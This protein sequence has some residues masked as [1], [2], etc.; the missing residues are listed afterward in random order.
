MSQPAFD[1]GEAEF[2][3]A[4]NPTYGVAELAEAINAQLRRGFTD[5]VWVRG[6]VNG[7]SDRG[8]HT[9]FSLI[10]QTDEGKAVLNVQLFAPA[11]RRLRPLLERNRLELRNGMKVRI[12]GHLDFWA[13]G[14]RLG[15]KMAGLD[16]RYTLGEIAQTRDDVMRRLAVSGLLDA[17]A[18]LPFPPLPL[19]VGVAASLDS[20]AWHDFHDEVLRSGHAFHVTVVDTRVQGDTAVPMVAGAV[21]TLSRLDL[22]VI[23]VIRGGGARNELAVFD[24]EPIAR[25]IATSPLPV[26]TG[27]GHEIDRSV[28]DEVAHLA[29]KTPTACAGELVKRVSTYIDSAEAQWNGILRRAHDI[30]DAAQFDVA[31]RAHRVARRTHAA[32][33]RSDERLAAR[34]AL[35]RSRVPSILADAEARLGEKKL[36]VVER[37]DVLLE[38]QAGRVERARLR[39]AALDPAVQ[40][41][42]GW[43]ITRLADGRLVRSADEATSGDELITVVADGSITSTVHDPT[44]SE[45][46]PTR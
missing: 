16:P 23:V 12:F 41:A 21:G 34:A 35:L 6:E 37:S 9:Y 46:G 40:L 42:R 45:T 13:Q 43:S 33:E 1:F 30:V 19:R 20:A 18:R 44:E 3:D 17:N 14:G 29:L 28:A 4:T 39:L 7:L 8:P 32:V 31:D 22:D 15:L 5:G 11:K 25:A 2:D 10:E 26:L 27:L 24:A 36:R 38:R